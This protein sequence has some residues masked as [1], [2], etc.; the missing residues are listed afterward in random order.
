M[1]ALVVYDPKSKFT[2]EALK[3]VTVN[4]AWQYFEEDSKGSLAA[5]KR[6]DYVILDQNPLDTDGEK[7]REIRVLATLKDGKAIYM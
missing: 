4:A 6:A 5:G 1:K 7:L 2:L 3:A